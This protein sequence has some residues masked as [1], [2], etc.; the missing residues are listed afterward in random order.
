MS[1]MSLL[2]M[3]ILLAPWINFFCLNVFYFYLSHS[4]PVLSNQFFSPFGI[5][6]SCLCVSLYFFYR[7]SDTVIWKYF[8]IS[9]NILVGR[10]SCLQKKNYISKCKLTTLAMSLKSGVFRR[11]IK[12]SLNALCWD[13]CGSALMYVSWRLKWSLWLA[14]MF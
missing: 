8:C 10:L 13:A 5:I 3:F 4:A 12:S 1:L 6:V 14:L 2:T 11:A 7:M 9:I